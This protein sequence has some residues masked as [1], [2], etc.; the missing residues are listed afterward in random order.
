MSIARH[1]DEIRVNAG[2]LQCKPL[3]RRIYADFHR[4]MAEWLP[5]E[6]SGGTAELGSGI[7]DITT[8]IPD[9]IRTDLTAR[10][11]ISRVENAYRLTFP[12][13]S[14]R[15]ILMFDVFHH[16]RY[17][18]QALEEIART[19]QPGGRIVLLEPGV[20]LLGRLVYGMLH[21]EPLALTDPI[22]LTAPPEWSPDDIDYYAAQG[23]A[24]RL[25]CWRKPAIQFA[26]LK[27]LK[28]Q[29]LSAVS[30]V[31]SGGYSGPQL[32]PG[33]LLPVMYALD[34]VLDYFPRIFG[35][36]LLVVLER[37]SEQD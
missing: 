11:G 22:Q 12:T 25:F 1:E 4:K 19:L 20:G 24:T 37:C 27:V 30:Y 23:N 35:T 6:L 5:A 33:R 26:G 16:L 31:A 14:L 17:P 34:R 10:E 21:P 18:Q 15:A 13:A 3:L 8:V 7:A 29:M 9:C 28:V 36:R 32:Y 2:S